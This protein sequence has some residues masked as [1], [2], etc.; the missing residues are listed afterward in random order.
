M[1]QDKEQEVRLQFLEEAEE[2]LDIIESGLLGIS[3]KKIDSNQID[4]VLRAAHSIKGGAAMMGFSQ[5]SNQAHHLE[6]FFKIL[7]AGKAGEID[8]K[9]EHLFLKSVDM[10]RKMVAVNRSGA[11]ISEEWE[12]TNVNP[13]FE[14]LH[15]RLGDYNP[16]MEASLLSEEAGEDMTVLLFET[17]VEGCLQRLE[18]ILE[19][20]EKPCLK[21]ELEIVAQ[22][23]GGLG[24]MLDLTAFSSLCK[25]ILEQLEL[26]PQE[27]EAI[28]KV[29]IGEWRRSQALVMIGQI[30]AL[31]TKIDLSGY[32]AKEETIAEPELS[33]DDVTLDS[34][35]L[36]LLLESNGFTE[37]AQDLFSSLAE[38][39]ISEEAVFAAEKEE[40][41]V[42]KTASVVKEEEKVS[43]IKTE[44]REVEP[45][46][47]TQSETTIRVPLRQLEQLTDLFGELSIERNGL[48]LQ[49]KSLRNLLNLL[50]NRVKTLEQ[51][52]FRLRTAYDKVESSSTKVEEKGNGNAES[53]FTSD[54]DFLEMDRYNDVHLLFQELMETIVQVQ[55]VTSDMEIN[56][57]DTEL[58]ARELNRTSKLM[59]G[60]LT[61]VRMRPV[62][63]LMARFPR[64]LRDMSLQYGKEV[65]LKVKG[66]S[67]LIDRS[68]LEALSDPLIHLLRNAFDH[69]I[70]DPAKRKALGKPEKGTIEIVA[71]YRGNQTVITISDDGGGISLEKIRAKV[72]DFL[73]LDER[74]IKESGE[75]ELLNLIFEPGFSTAEKV[76]DLSGR[77]VGMD[78]V[79]TNLRQVRGDILVDTKEGVGTTF[80]ITVPF[81]LSVVRVLLVESAS[82]LLAIPTNS[83]EEM[84]RLE[85][86][87]AIE[88]VGRE[89]LN[90]GGYMVP[91]VRL[92]QWLKFPTPPQMPQTETIPLIDMPTVL[93]IAVGDD[94]VGIQVERY[95]GEQEVTIRPVEGNLPM[96]PGFTGCTILGDGRVV[97]LMDAIALLRWIEDRGAKTN[98]SQMLQKVK[99]GFDEAHTPSVSQKNTVMVVDDSINVR[100]FLA[101]TLEKAGYRV[102]QAKDGQ[103]AIEKLQGGSVV[104]A[105]VCDIEMPRLDGYGFLAHVK[106]D[107]NCKNIPVAMLTSRSGN[108]HRQ[109]AINLG[110][111]A[112]F[113]KPFKEHELLQTLKEFTRKQLQTV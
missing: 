64:V 98:I 55:E 70:E 39:E 81:T 84:L 106:A 20:P 69:G 57:E 11:T 107:P 88:S 104:N 58:K 37:A 7:K 38:K 86:D 54:F 82:M 91:L 56:L 48:D 61:K 95:W 42:E 75:R 60:N 5:L 35:S 52:N 97:P 87:M 47:Q 92:S 46:K 100:R 96:P 43:K 62:S 3:T 33:L 21:E 80:T 49:L 44:V 59:Q 16:E 23:L 27:V 73:G 12:K 1:A 85:P 108:K 103:E 112:Y 93:M 66:G 113:S 77:G 41:V 111:S 4:G 25:S 15:D 67:T 10:L 101:L 90:W 72:K 18:A 24:E 102:E 2:Y 78:I 30:G 9:L 19:N 94:L 65:D 71:A 31:P 99:P 53:S 8:G 17:E 34:E 14:Q 51:S 29:G 26:Q 105:V 6:D 28:A 110:A 83:V 40:K 36:D 76:T 22:E 74:E 68:I 79:R 109:L 63:D 32:G 45:E 50:R 13:I 89:V